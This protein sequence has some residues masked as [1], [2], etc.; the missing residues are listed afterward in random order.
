MA[1]HVEQ[2]GN[3]RLMCLLGQ[4]GFA[5][6]Y[7]GEHIYLK[8][9]A[10]IKVL[11]VHLGHEELDAFLNE[12]RTVARLVHPHIVRVLEFGVEGS[13]PFL[14]MDYAP[15]GT[16]R[17]RHPKG[18]QLPLETVI[19]YVKQVAAALQHAHDK[20]LVH[21]DVKPENM[22]LSANDDILLSDFGI[23]LVAQSSQQQN[24][25]DAVGTLAYMAPEQLQGKPRPATDQYALGIIIYEWLSGDHPFH[26]TFTEVASQHMLVTPAPLHE[27]VPDIPPAVEQVVMTAL[28]KDPH[29]RFASVQ[30][31]ATALEQAYLSASPP[32][33]V[34]PVMAPQ[35]NGGLSR[36]PLRL[37]Q[38]PFST[39]I[40]PL[41][42]KRA[43]AM[44][45]PSKLTVPVTPIVD[46]PL[47]SPPQPSLLSTLIV[48]SP[49][50]VA[51]SDQANTSMTPMLGQPTA[52]LLTPSSS[53]GKSE[54]SPAPGSMPGQANQPTAPLPALPSPVIEPSSAATSEAGQVSRSTLVIPVSELTPAS[55]PDVATRPLDRSPQT[56]VA[57]R[58]SQPFQKTVS[59]RA[60]IAGLAG[61]ASLT[62]LGSTVALFAQRSHMRSHLSNVT[63][64]PT[65]A[66]TQTPIVDATSSPTVG[67]T[68]THHARHTP[69]PMPTQQPTATPIST[70][71][72]T[73]APTATPGP[74]PTP[75]SIVSSG[76]STLHGNAAYDFDKGL[77]VAS[78]N[79][80]VFWDLQ[81]DPT[82]TLD[83]VGNAQLAN[84][85]VTDFNS[86]D[87]TT[88]QGQS[89]S[90]TPLNG[91]NDASNTLVNNDVFA[92]AT[93]GGHHAKVLVV[94][95]GSDL[96]IQWVTYQG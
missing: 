5:D 58:E 30:M 91:N 72:P 95:Y 9:Q 18:T 67:T 49:A 26:G 71:T 92:V 51:A 68:H 55:L 90:T 13:I 37:G 75:V 2:L 6:V 76:T 82:R 84:L 50:P 47:I 73:P 35:P 17:Q 42:N 41:Q 64:T 19:H 11:Q 31:F 94:S 78:G 33:A 7:L 46:Q 22:L 65:E 38:S 3:Y 48:P 10:A 87:L 25:E 69:T 83:P 61:L 77:E 16:L 28:A 80:D 24:V 81:N 53:P 14:V 88:L 57:T 56:G 36:Q 54:P 20:K 44:P 1:D 85:G 59:R 89:Y 12:A 79:G 40:M 60:V 45:S 15:N 63:S 32:E 93:N 52:P 96:Q 66:S 86:V 8:T 74:T 70:D 4:G 27:K 39:S 34:R 62:V 21:R 23:A 29:Q 43:D